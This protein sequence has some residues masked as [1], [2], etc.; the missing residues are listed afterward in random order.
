MSIS[1]TLSP[2]RDLGF[3][4]HKHPDKAQSFG[5]AVGTAH[6]VWP[7]AAAER[8]TVALILEVDPIALVRGKGNRGNEGFSLAQYVNDRPY[9]AS[10]MMAVA[11]GKVFRTAMAGRCEARPERAGAAIPLRSAYLR[12]RAGETAASWSDCSLRS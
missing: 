10:S 5:V 4:L 7:E 11:L 8:S 6:V 9:A 3:L 1:T 12:C 2:A